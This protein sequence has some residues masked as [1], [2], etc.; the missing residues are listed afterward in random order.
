M[1]VTGSENSENRIE[2]TQ[3]CAATLIFFLSEISAVTE[4]ST[5]FFSVPTIEHQIF[6]VSIIGR[7]RFKNPPINGN[8]FV[9]LLI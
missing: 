3:S 2:K 6:E 1:K 9:I 4:I 8:F 5:I 7:K